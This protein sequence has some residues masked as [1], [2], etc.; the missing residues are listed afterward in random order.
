MVKKNLLVTGG[1]LAVGA[2]ALGTGFMAGG[3]LTADASNVL[4]SEPIA[5]TFESSYGEASDWDHLLDG[6]FFFRDLDLVAG[7]LESVTGITPILEETEYGGQSWI[8]ENEDGSITGF[9]VEEFHFDQ[10]GNI[11][12]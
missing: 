12:E 9:M 7:E 8:L 4:Q 3:G 10:D 5:E 6:D 2:L 11:I 1:V